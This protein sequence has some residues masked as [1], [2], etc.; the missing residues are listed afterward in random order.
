MWKGHKSPK[1]QWVRFSLPSDRKGFVSYEDE[2]DGWQ[3]NIG[4]RAF[5]GFKTRLQA[6]R[7]LLRLRK[8][9]KGLY[10]INHPD[11][12]ELADLIAAEGKGDRDAYFKLQDYTVS[13]GYGDMRWSLSSEDGEDSIYFDF[14]RLS[15]EVGD[16]VGS[17]YA[18][19]SAIDCNTGGFVE[20]YS[21]DVVT[22]EELQS[23]IDSMIDS[24]IE[25]FGNN[26]PNQMNRIC[27]EAEKLRV[28]IRGA[29]ARN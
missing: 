18:V 21:A 17:Y 14:T 29:I 25:W 11:D 22:V 20:D 13:D 10:F 8:R 23:T 15:D 9:D 24:A 1:G 27:D 3:A 12:A 26:Y 16:W 7:F 5:P 4:N 6:E 2:G 19:Q 28:E